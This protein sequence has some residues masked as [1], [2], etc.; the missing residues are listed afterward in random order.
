MSGLSLHRYSSDDDKDDEDDDGG[1]TEDDDDDNN[2][3]GTMPPPPPPK[4][5]PAMRAIPKLSM[6]PVRV[7]E[8]EVQ[9]STLA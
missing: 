6:P 7:A 4:A 8:V 2:N 1:A 9:S 5:T 3:G